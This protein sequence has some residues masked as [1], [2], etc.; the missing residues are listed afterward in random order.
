MAFT[1]K[2]RKDVGT[3]TPVTS[4]TQIDT[5]PHVAGSSANAHDAPGT[6]HEGAPKMVVPPIVNNGQSTKR[7]GEQLIGSRLITPEQLEAA[8]AEQTV[9]GGRLGEVLVRMGVL[10]EQALAHAL[11]AFFGFDVAD[12]RRDNVDPATLTLVPENVAR[13]YMAVPIRMNGTSL[14]VAVAEPS[15]ELRAALSQL[16]GRTVQLRIAPLSDIRWAIDSNYRAI[17][18]VG[19][20]VQAFESVEGSR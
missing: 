20:L 13:E 10:T 16:V 17:G 3:P 15:E 18:T 11:A 14:E 19:Q 2:N 5:A 8:L 4:S 12:L 9:S 7:L 6:G 1:R